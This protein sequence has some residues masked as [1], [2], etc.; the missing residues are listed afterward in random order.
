MARTTTRPADQVTAAAHTIAAAAHRQDRTTPDH[1]DF[2][3]L[4]LAAER[5]LDAL[6]E[7][8]VVLEA[9]AATYDEG[10]RLRTDTDRG[11]AEVLGS[12]LTHGREL[13]AA[14]R[15]GSHTAHQMAGEFARLA[16]LPDPDDDD[17]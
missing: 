17:R 16:V 12:A 14:L 6:H 9:Q 5:A 3:A 10:R 15:T 4:A 1:R 11:P 8:A 2:Y 13:Q 7:I